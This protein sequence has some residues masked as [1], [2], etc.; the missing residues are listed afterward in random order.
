MVDERTLTDVNKVQIKI[1]YLTYL[2]K[3]ITQQAILF[4]TVNIW[5]ILIK[6][7][8]KNF[9]LHFLR[10]T[11]CLGSRLFWRFQ[12]RCLLFLLFI[13]KTMCR[14]MNKTYFNGNSSLSHLRV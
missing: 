2:N 11:G 8:K 14:K 10:L 1:I 12:P 6:P 7:M 9:L 4:D 3:F 5:Q 13:K